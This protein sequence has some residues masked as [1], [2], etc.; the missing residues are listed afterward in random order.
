MPTTLQ[1]GDI[2][3]VGFNF[4][5]PDEFTFLALRDLAAGTEITFTDNG[6]QSAGTF[7]ANEGT[8]T[9]TASAAVA[10]GTLVSPAVSSVLFSAS[11]DQILAY[12]GDADSPT[13]I[14]ALN[15]EGSP[16]TWQADATSSNTSALPAGL[17]DGETAVAL[18]E[19][20][21]AIYSGI[22]TGTRADLLAAINDAANWTGSN[23]D[24]QAMP[25][26]PF[27]VLDATP[28]TPVINEILAS[29]AGTDDTEFVE[30]FGTAGQSLD[31]L[32][33]IGVESDNISTNG[34]IDFRFDFD[35]S[36]VI[37]D[38]GFF[39]LGN[40]S[41]LDPNYGVAPN[42]DLAANSLE[43][44][45]ATYAL[46]QTA[47]LGGDMVTG[48]EEVVDSV[49]LWDGG[50]GDSFFFD[51]PVVGPDGS[52]LPA[53]ARR[54]ED[55]VD[56]DTAADWALG[57]FNLG[58]ANTPTAGTDV[59]PDPDPE[60]VEP[61]LISTIQGTGRASPLLGQTVT[62]NAIVV[63]DF[64][65]GDGDATRN[66]GGFYLQEE[67]SDADGN[68][69]SSEG[70]F[71]FDRF[72]DPFFDVEWGD[73]VIVTGTVSEFFGETQITATR[74]E[75]VAS[76]QGGLVT[77]ATIDL[78]TTG[79][80]VN[81]DGDLI[82]DLEAYEG[83]LVSVADTL[84]VTEM[85]NYDRFGEIRASEGGQLRQFTQDNAPS[86]DGFAAHLEDVAARTITIDD[87]QTVQNPDPV[88]VPDG[89]AF[90][91][92]TVFRMGDELDDLLG[93]VRFSRGSGGSGDETYRLN[94]VDE[95]TIT[96]TN[97]RPE[98]VPDVGGTITAASV[99][100]LNFFSTLDLS[101]NT[102]G[103][104]NL[105]PRGAD[106]QFEFDRQQEKLVEA[107]V[108]MDADIYGLVEIE[109]D[110]RPGSA[111]NAV[112][113]L[114]A[115]MNAVAGA[116]TYD[117][118]YPG[119]DF[120][121]VS[122]AISNA[123]VYKTATVELTEGSSVAILD[124][125]ALAALDSS[126]G[127]V[128]DGASTNRAA[129]AASFTEIETGGAVT[130]TVNHFKS[131]GSIFDVDNAAIGDGQANNN[132]L[133]VKAA[134]AID[135][136]LAS[137]PTGTGDEDVLILG[138]LNAY[139]KE[140]PI[141]T[142][143]ASG[144][145]NLEKAFLEPGAPDYSFVFDGQVGTLDYALANESLLGQVT[146][147]AVWDVNA[148]E[149]DLIDYNTDFGRPQEIFDGSTPFRFSDHDPILVGMTLE[150]PEPAT[151]FAL[152]EFTDRRFGGN[153]EYSLDGEVLDVER[154][155]ILQREIELEEAGLTITADDGGRRT[156]EFLTTEGEGLGVR[157]LSRDG[158]FKS[159]RKALDGRESITFT[160]D[161]VDGLGDALSVVFE[162][163]EARRSGEVELT[164]F[165]D[166]AEVDQVS[167]GLVD[168]QVSYD[169]V[170]DLSFDAVEIGV[171]GRLQV[172]IGA[173]GF[174]R[175]ILEDEFVFV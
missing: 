78:P 170:G 171:D 41:G 55:G 134:E 50:V 162:F 79:T 85:F 56:T 8:F 115:A 95:A 175:L 118:V 1:P 64:Q 47:S 161:D 49:A 173:V 52:F 80:V 87:G 5:N 130:V 67:D 32:S 165:D 9:W 48:A 147:A 145:T 89:T 129:L 166:G 138:D 12:Q 38:N 104:A 158:A 148:P 167:L 107:L 128:F 44:S 140:D 93:V 71:V 57:A 27:T 159:D 22:T 51:A 58:P 149:P 127:T 116:G 42:V 108:Q 53:G 90:E 111:G 2:A 65:N 121:D 72:T 28:T 126:F 10:A 69:L 24:R 164:F 143:E 102:S 63:G 19:I 37:G 6:W 14:A 100:V 152:I 135:L 155:R 160:L 144:F 91:Q 73:Q 88:L 45:S 174:D 125:T 26:A 75:R 153:A 146:G 120:V 112:E 114:V 20:D 33:L 151:A 123:F 18:D 117:W 124:D 106:S 68:L 92:S 94:L 101:G 40:P 77:A 82:A 113:T 119:R 136:W 83:M 84:T 62:V 103:P 133:R 36:H 11:G 4:D 35:A 39:L 25:T 163:A 15:A 59:E 76:D 109:N 31:G 7:R 54:V 46:V 70:I 132:P 168:D 86:V 142:L 131:K 99:N 154:L 150:A 16:G 66:L 34:T 60:P 74:V 139:A 157:S 43:N 13:F 21:N 98:G 29:H 61:T 23:S 122:D 172:E 97:P 105:G 110:F 169:L 96:S 30:I 3:F 17:V 137:D 81:A 141:T 156:P